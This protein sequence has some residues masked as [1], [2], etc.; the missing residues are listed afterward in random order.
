MRGH[1]AENSKPMVVKWAG[2]IM[3]IMVEKNQR[4]W[5]GWQCSVDNKS[6]ERTKSKMHNLTHLCN[7]LK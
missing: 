4:V 3:R 6:I 5:D 1:M 2:G 7:I